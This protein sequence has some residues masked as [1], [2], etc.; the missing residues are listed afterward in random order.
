MKDCYGKKTNL[1]P[2]EKDDGVNENTVMEV[3]KCKKW[4]EPVHG[5]KSVLHSVQWERIILDEAH[6]IKNRHCNTAKAIFALHS[7]YK[8]ALSGTPLQNSVEELY[9]LVHFL[10]IDP[11]SMFLCKDC[12]CNVF[13][14]SSMKDCS[15]CSHSSVR[16][17]SWWNKHISTP[18][19]DT[20][21][22]RK[23]AMILLKKKVL[24]SILLR[25]TKLERASDLAL[26]PRIVTLRRD[27][28]DRNEGEFYEALYTQSRLQ[29]GTLL[30]IPISWS[31][32]ILQT[33]AM[34]ALEMLTVVSV[35][36]KQRISWLHLVI[37]S[38]V[39]VVY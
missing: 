24:S 15:N 36:I 5:G 35:M 22:R 18:V 26:P 34:K 3:R 20:T 13:D 38:S 19:R 12:N 14:F 31:I 9:S 27:S 21:L 23:H 10:R 16:H 8:W 29:F 6:Y 30:T 32:L 17:F 2:K 25:R 33:S 4:E 7:L 39:R 37:I 11:Y 1:T 28:L